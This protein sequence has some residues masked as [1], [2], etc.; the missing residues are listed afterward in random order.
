MT[1]DELM[2]IH[3]N[4]MDEEKVWELAVDGEKRGRLFGFGN[5][6]RTCK[7]VRELE[8]VEASASDPT[9]STATSAEEPNRK[10]SREE[11]DRF[12]AESVAATRSDIYSQIAAQEKRHQAELDQIRLDTKLNNA[13]FE[14]LFRQTGVRPPNLGVSFE[15]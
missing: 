4:E 8:A 5:R 7:A 2:K 12:V 3:G 11:V 1:Y 6:S 15:T 14:A 9:K 13:R 10:Y